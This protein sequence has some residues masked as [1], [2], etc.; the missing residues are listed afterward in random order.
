MNICILSTDQVN[1]D[2]RLVEAAIARGHKA[3]IHNMRNVS[4]ALRQ[5]QPR[6]YAA[7]KDISATFDVVIPRLNVGYSDY[8][9]NL[10]QQ[11]ICCHTYV[12]ET[13]D[14]L[15]L[16]RDKL[17]CLQYLLA[18]GL[19]FPTTCISCKPEEFR[20][21]TEHTGMPV[22]V[23]L[24]DSTEGVG[25]F[26]ANTFKELDNL[27]HTFD[28]FHADYVIQSFI[29]ESKGTDVRAFVVNGRVI[30]AMERHSP[31]G[32]FRANVSLGAVASPCALTTDEEEIVIAATQAIG[33]NVAGVDLIRSKEGPML[34]EINVSPDFTGEQGIECVT[35]ID[36]AGA[37]IDF[38]V[39]QTQPFYANHRLLQLCSSTTEE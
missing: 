12:S 22:V 16:G 21:L 5:D 28:R 32:D 39:Q 35:G 29:S 34:L 31:D 6:I 1:D 30:A 33:I 2:Q 3:C 14:A 8:G 11:F 4:L 18:Q 37:I 7:D 38:T 9:I 15:R 26:V 24:I 27:V 17:K 19:P 13:P 20:Q 10:I 25:I 23:K 36:V